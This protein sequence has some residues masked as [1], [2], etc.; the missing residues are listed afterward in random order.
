[1]VRG[2]LE[3]LGPGN[4]MLTSA[5]MK[6]LMVV[7]LTQAA[8]QISTDQVVRTVTTQLQPLISQAVADALSSSSSFSSSSG[9]NRASAAV[10]VVNAGL[11]PEEEA[12]YNRKL[13]ANAAY[14]FSYQVGNDEFQTYL[15]QEETRE[16]ANVQ[17][18]YSYVDPTG[19]LI[20][21]TYTAGPDGY[22]EQRTVEENKVVM[23][24]IP[25]PWQGPYA[26]VDDVA[27]AV[28]PEVPSR[29]VAVAAPAP[30]VDQEALIRLIINQLQPSISSA[31]QT[32]I[33][34]RQAPTDTSD[35]DL[36]FAGN[37]V[38]I[39]TPDSFIQY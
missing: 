21:V 24:N 3:D 27:V 14:D 15:T 5:P 20:T 31:V 32:A 9:F 39:E 4:T 19:D 37:N 18:K 26:G 38:R 11:T 25:G 8:P 12:E 35:V 33:S 22:N 30:A 13:N 2:Q 34:S 28:V 36:R 6:L 7:G 23:R 1:M 10:G 29:P 16:G 17:G